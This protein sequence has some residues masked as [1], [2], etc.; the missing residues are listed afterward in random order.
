MENEYQPSAD[1]NNEN[2]P[3]DEDIRTMVRRILFRLF[4]PNLAK[5][6]TVNLGKIDPPELYF[7]RTILVDKKNDLVNYH[8]LLFAKMHKNGQNVSDYYLF[9]Y[10]KLS[11]INDEEASSSSSENK[12]NEYKLKIPI[13]SC[14][15]FKH[16]IHSFGLQIYSFEKNKNHKE[17]MENREENPQKECAICL[18]SFEDGKLTMKLHEDYQHGFHKKCITKWVLSQEQL[19]CPI[20]NRNA[21]QVTTADLQPIF[22]G[23][24]QPST[25]FLSLNPLAF[26]FQLANGKTENDQIKR[27]QAKLAIK[28]TEE[29]VKSPEQKLFEIGPDGVKIHPIVEELKKQISDILSNGRQNSEEIIAKAEQMNSLINRGVRLALFIENMQLI[30]E[31]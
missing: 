26:L 6:Y 17:K 9:G 29:F 25:S 24:D 18:E 30:S 15:L 14:A 12:F 10:A 27:K 22:D 28:K 2:P 4:E 11:K 31:N 1:E 3:D 23:P 8:A 13:N 20:C 5:V 21:F 16:F 7:N 19:R